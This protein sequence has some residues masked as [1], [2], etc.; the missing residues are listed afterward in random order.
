M[1]EIQ[2]IKGR[3]YKIRWKMT[4]RRKGAREYEEGDREMCEWRRGLEV[5]SSE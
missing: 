5:G 4:M 1:G 3:R 2:A